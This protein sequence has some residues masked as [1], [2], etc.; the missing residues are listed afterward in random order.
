[1]LGNDRLTLRSTIAAGLAGLASLTGLAV[2]TLASP[3]LA[4]PALARP[5]LAR[6]TPASPPPATPAPAP[7]GAGSFRTWTAASRAAGYRLYVPTHTFGLT[8]TYPILV[9]RCSASRGIRYD[10]FAQWGSRT[11]YLSLDQ[12][13]TG[14]PC[15]N[16]GPATFIRTYKAGGQ[17]YVL[18]GFC[19]RRGLPSCASSRAV[20]VLVWK[21]GGRYYVA[22]SHDEPAGTLVTFAAS[23]RKF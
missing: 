22:Y 7:A 13:N 19:G 18:Y 2:L 9:S 11:T 16:F 10:A 12:N 23:I 3:A 6:P 17:S 5:A 1:M 15:S 20:L 8:R 21:T 4:S 14:G